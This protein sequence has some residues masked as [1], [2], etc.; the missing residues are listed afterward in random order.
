[1]PVTRA[2]LQNSYIANHVGRTNKL[3]VS[4]FTTV[5]DE[6]DIANQYGCTKLQKDLTYIQYWSDFLIDKLV[7][8]LKAHFVDSTIIVI[9][10]QILISWNIDVNLIKPE[11][12]P[13]PSNK[14]GNVENENIKIEISVPSQIRTRSS[15][16]VRSY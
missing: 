12:E 13:V 1:M 9:N 10:R 2:E 4:M 14:K 3:V 5:C 11:P 7:D 15:Y 16:A 8:M 6:I